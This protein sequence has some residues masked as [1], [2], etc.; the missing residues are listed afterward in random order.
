MTRRKVRV[1]RTIL[2]TDRNVDEDPEYMGA[3]SD[4]FVVQ[5]GTEVVA[6]DW[7][8]PGEVAITLLIPSHE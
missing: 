8:V 5:D 1:M 3:F 7:S 2:K 4:P 6:V